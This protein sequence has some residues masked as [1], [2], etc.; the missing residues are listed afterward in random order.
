MY[1]HFRELAQVHVREGIVVASTIAA[2]VQAAKVVA[3]ENSEII[4]DDYFDA[5]LRDILQGGEGLLV[6]RRYTE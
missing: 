1:E 6:G 2:M 5:C 4:G 3:K